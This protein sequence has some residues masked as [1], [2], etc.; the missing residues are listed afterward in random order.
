MLAGLRLFGQSYDLAIT[1]IMY[2]PDSSLN[3]QDWVELYNY[4]NNSDRHQRMAAQ[5]R[6]CAG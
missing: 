2:N 6:R 3:G 5:E 1:E 4:G